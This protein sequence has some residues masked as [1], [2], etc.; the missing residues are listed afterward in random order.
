MTG[1][2]TH[3]T[4]HSHHCRIQ[5]SVYVTA[6]QLSVYVTAIQL[7]VYVTAIQLSVYATAI[8]TLTY[9]SIKLVTLLLAVIVLSHT[10]N[11]KE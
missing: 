4:K 2:L 5:L 9:P 8:P 1:P 3:Y 6:I 10:K 11:C 7:S